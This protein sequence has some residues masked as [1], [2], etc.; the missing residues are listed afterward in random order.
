MKK[1]SVDGCSGKHHAKGYCSAHY[2]QILKYGYIK[3]KYIRQ[4]KNDVITKEDYAEL[5]LRDINGNETGRTLVDKDDLE[6]ATQYTWSLHSGGYA[7]CMHKGK[8]TYLHR[9]ILGLNEE[10][11]EVD[12]INRNKLD[13]RKANLRVCE[14]WVNASNK[15]VKNEN[16]YLGVRN[17]KRNLKKPFIARIIRNK[18]LYELGYFETK[19][20][21]I[22]ARLKAQE[23]LDRKFNIMPKGADNH[24]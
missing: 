9:V 17:T 12:H 18:K 15:G 23:R 3:K 19:R 16:G 2:G 4:F 24:Y 21:A 20:E 1:C 8:T 13:N 11:K 22:E 10:D 6:K 5:I 14:H 7:R